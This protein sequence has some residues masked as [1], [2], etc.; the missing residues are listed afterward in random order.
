MAG[1]STLSHPHRPQRLSRNELKHLDEKQLIFELVRYRICC[2]CQAVSIPFPFPIPFPSIF[3]S[4]F[5]TIFPFPLPTAPCVIKFYDFFDFLLLSYLF[6]IYPI[7]RIYLPLSFFF[8]A[9]CPFSCN[10]CSLP[11]FF[12]SLFFST[13]II[14]FIVTSLSYFRIESHLFFTF[15][16][17]LFFDFTV[18]P[19]SS[20]QR[21]PFYL[22]FSPPSS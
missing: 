1:P 16:S 5:Y 20:F 9:I 17:T 18:Y 22:T 7:F 4:I 19:L 15:K 6:V 14:I 3:L 21:R 8:T 11:H 2:L 13:V 12:L 10:V